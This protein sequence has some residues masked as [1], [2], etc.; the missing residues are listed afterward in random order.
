MKALARW[1]VTEKRERLGAIMVGAV[2]DGCWKPFV[3]KLRTCPD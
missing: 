2:K 3:A 1:A